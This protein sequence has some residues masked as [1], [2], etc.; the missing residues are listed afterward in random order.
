MSQNDI[1]SFKTSYDLQN[2]Y[3]WHL[4]SW[5]ELWFTEQSQNDIYPFETSI[6][7]QNSHKMR[8]SHFR[9]YMIYRPFTK[10]HLLSWYELWFTE[11][12]QDGIYSVETRYDLINSL[13]RVFTELRWFLLRVRID[14]N[15]IIPSHIRSVYFTCRNKSIFRIQTNISLWI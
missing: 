13:K 1:Y 8:F 11:Q 2:S 5:Y 4:L 10:W 6:D 7:I 14:R 12:W 3:K 15:C 9:R